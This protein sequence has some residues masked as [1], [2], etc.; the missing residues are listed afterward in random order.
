MSKSDIVIVGAG[1]SGLMAG[2][3]LAKAGKKVTVLEARDRV[4]GRIHTIT[5]QTYTPI[6]LGAEFIHGDLPVTLAL[7]KEA[8]VKYEHAG[9][10]MWRFKNGK[11]SQEEEQMEGWSELMDKLE[12][13]NV[14]IDLNSFLEQNFADKKYENLKTSVRNYVAGYDTANPN[15]VS[16]FALRQEWTN[17]DDE[18]QHRLTNGYCGMINFLANEIK[19][20]GGTIELNSIVK[21]VKWEAANV[22]VVTAGGLEY[23]AGKVLIALPLGVLQSVNKDASVTFEPPIP[24]QQDALQ[25]IGF[26]AIIKVLLHFKSLFW[27]NA[28]CGTESMAFMFSEEA[29]PTWWTQAPRHA[30]LLTG[31]L[32]GPPAMD[33]V[34]STDKELLKMALTSLSH[35]FSKPVSWLKEQLV[36]SHI[37][38]WTADPFTI[39]SYAYDKLGSVEARKVL[40]DPVSKTIY[41][42]GEYLYQGPA[43]GTVEAALTSAKKTAK[44]IINL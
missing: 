17:E 6:E 7:L 9:G 40:A 38:N 31:W 20:N 33:L 32:G 37:A 26:G 12:K 27:E 22:K 11:I 24:V 15:K 29:V 28:G 30:P 1:A 39:G 10:E 43:M 3:M 14:D 8:G 25:Q 16:A 18:A 36:S 35:I 19:N 4:G 13:L 23:V 5:D 21:M 41:F 2:C 34:C 44:K 42:A